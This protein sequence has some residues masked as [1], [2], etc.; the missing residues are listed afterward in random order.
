MLFP[1]KSISSILK[2]SVIFRWLFIDILG[3]NELTL[4]ERNIPDTYGTVS[5]VLGTFTGLVTIFLSPV[6]ITSV[7]FY[8]VLVASIL[9]SPELGLL[10]SIL[11]FPVVSS[12]FWQF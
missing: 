5:F 12:S 7:I 11:L 3:V 4:R 8:T 10:L 2:S 1:K 6:L 9:Y